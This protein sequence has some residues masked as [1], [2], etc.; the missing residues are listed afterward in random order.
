VN[1]S[2][3]QQMPSESDI[4]SNLLKH[5]TDA[6]LKTLLSKFIL[7]LYATYKDLYFTYLEINPLGRVL[8]LF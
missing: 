1:T 2:D 7:D 3:A 8:L 6:T 5:I 4:Q